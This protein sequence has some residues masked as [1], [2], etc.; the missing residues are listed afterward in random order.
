MS[1]FA[2][3]TPQKSIGY[4]DL[5]ERARHFIETAPRDLKELAKRITEATPAHHV[6]SVTITHPNARTRHRIISVYRGPLHDVIEHVAFHIATTGCTQQYEHMLP[7]LHAA[8]LQHDD[9][10]E[11]TLHTNLY[12]G[13]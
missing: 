1:L 11:I 2:G 4:P 13:D 12:A 5:A 3:Y 9:E 8:T 6:R 7:T 10:I